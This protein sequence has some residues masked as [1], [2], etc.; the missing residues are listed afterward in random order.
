MV[1][2][3]PG[4]LFRSLKLPETFFAQSESE[5]EPEMTIR[6]HEQHITAGHAEKTQARQ[7]P[8]LHSM[9]IAKS[10]HRPAACFRALS[11]CFSSATKLCTYA[12]FLD[13]G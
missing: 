10:T 4:R 1:C 2:K 9:R 5:S 11:L 3:I 12:E 7:P 6:S 13:G 8:R